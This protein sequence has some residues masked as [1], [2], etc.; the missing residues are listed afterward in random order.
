[1]IKRAI[2]LLFELLFLL[3]MLVC[4]FWHNLAIYGLS[5]GSGQLSMVWNAKPVNE[6]L[7]DTT[8]PNDLKQK[9][10]LITAIKQYAVDSLGINS[11]DNYST[12]YDQ[13][14]K[15][16]L[17]NVTACEPFSFTPKEWDF[18]FLGTVSY[19]GFF[20]KEAAKKE[21]LSLKVNDYDVDVY[22]PSGWSTLGWFQ[23]PILSNMLKNSEGDLSNLIIHE[24]THGTLYVKN[25]VNFNENLANFI[26]DKGAQKFLIHT[27]G[28]ES[29]QYIDYEQKKEDEKIFTD[30]ILKG[31]ERL[32]SLYK[33]IATSNDVILKKKLKTKLIT[34]IVVGVNKLPLHKKQNYFKYSLQAFAEGNA[35]FM[36]FT[37][38]DSQYEIFDK[39]F[40]EKYN[41]DLKKYLNAMKEK[42]PSL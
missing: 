19:K 8:F 16:I 30:Y 18:P 23:D 14:D 28:K 41:S 29:K 4:L 9:L 27:F 32:D 36:A 10:M 1:M 7:Q 39:E 11:S 38:Y 35:F 12:V 13:K 21:I 34:E 2:A 25:N 17:F 6:L 31:V 40:T 20:N 5:Q 3:L 15:A 24:L 26:G 37:R 22:S 42:Y 33:S